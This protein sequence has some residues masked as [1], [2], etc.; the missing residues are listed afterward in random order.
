MRNEAHISEEGYKTDAMSAMGEWRKV[1]GTKS[2]VEEAKERI[3]R[4]QNVYDKRE[5]DEW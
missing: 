3:R 5:K 2:E 1:V 4:M